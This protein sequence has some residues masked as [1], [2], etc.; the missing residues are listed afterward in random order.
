M[1]SAWTC[2][3]SR[4][5]EYLFYLAAFTKNSVLRDHTCWSICEFP[6]FSKMQEHSIVYIAYLL[7]SFWHLVHIFWLVN[8]VLDFTMLILVSS[9]KSL[10]VLGSTHLSCMQI[11]N[12]F[13]CSLGCFSPVY[14][15]HTCHKSPLWLWSHAYTTSMSGKMCLLM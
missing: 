4:S 7:C 13:C 1:I 2:L 14:L 15:E 3:V 8:K 9:R 11:A 10:E 12:I 5:S 6:S